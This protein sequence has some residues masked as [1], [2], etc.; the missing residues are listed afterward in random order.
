MLQVGTACQLAL[1]LIRQL[2]NPNQQVATLGWA[3]AV[4]TGTVLIMGLLCI[5]GPLCKPP[6]A[7]R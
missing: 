3:S 6:V 1:H 4:V 7:D 2:A 5:M